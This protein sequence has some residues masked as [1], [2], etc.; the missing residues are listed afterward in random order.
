[1]GWYNV[2]SE[3]ETHEVKG[4]K[5][6]AWGFYDMHGNVWE[7]C[8]DW[9]GTYPSGAVT[10]P[11]GASGDYRVLRGGSWGNDARDCR[12]ANRYRCMPGTRGGI[13]GFRLACSALP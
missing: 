5:A 10:D 12:S 7:W 6:N 13:F 9:Y 3:L 8:Q 4:K 2:N 11:T 1:M